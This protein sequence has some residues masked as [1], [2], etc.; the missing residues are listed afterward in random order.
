VIEGRTGDDGDFVGETRHVDD[1]D[2]VVVGYVGY[3]GEMV[4]SGERLRGLYKRRKRRPGSLSEVA[5]KAEPAQYFG[6]K[7]TLTPTILMEIGEL[8]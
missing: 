3:V 8:S 5:E 4:Y 6:F 7:L 2:D 1:D